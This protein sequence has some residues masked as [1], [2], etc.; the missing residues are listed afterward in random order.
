MSRIKGLVLSDFTI[1]MMEHL[2]I[3]LISLVYIVDQ[4]DG[5]AASKDITYQ[6]KS[7]KLRSNICKTIIVGCSIDACYFHTILGQGS[8]LIETN[9]LHSCT[10]D[11]FLA[12]SSIDS[13]SVKSNQAKRVSEVEENGQRSWETVGDEVEE[14]EEDHDFFDVKVKHLI[15]CGP[16]K[17]EADYHDL[18]KEVD[19]LLEE[20]WLFWGFR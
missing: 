3:Y 20:L 4:L 8:S 15:D 12:F 10:L 19:H 5:M 1:D 17:D 2:Q 13:V 14:S 18:S 6:R 11:S 9:S 7:T 16:I